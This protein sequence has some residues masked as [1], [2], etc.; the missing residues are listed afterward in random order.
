MSVPVLTSKPRY[1]ILDGLRG[2]AA[3]LV[4]AFH[5]FE[6]YSSGP[7]DQI[8]NHGY[9]AVDFFFV[10]SGFV[11]G[12]AYDDRWTKGLTLGEFA[13]RRLIRLH[14]MV[15][16]G[17]LLG[18]ALF[19]FASGSPEFPLVAQTPGWKV[20]VVALICFTMIPLGKGL[21][22]RG[23]H[24]TNP[25]NG[26]TWSLQ[27]EYLANALYAL[28]I[29]R[30]RTWMLA[31]FVAAAAFL[32]LNLALNWDIFNT[33]SPRDYAKYTVI[34]GWAL[35]PSQLTV[36]ISRLLYPFFAGLLL[37]RLRWIIPVR[38]YGFEL[39]TLLVAA[40]LCMPRVVVPGCPWANGAY[41]AAAIILVCPLIVSLGAGSTL[42]SGAMS[43]V[44]TFLGAISYPIY[45]T[46][47]PLV[48]LH[49]AW[50]KAHPEAAL[51][52]R[53][54]LGVSVWLLAMAV[55]Y[56]A[57]KL[58]DL[59]VRAWL[60]GK[61]RKHGAA[62]VHTA[63]YVTDLIRARD[64]FVTYFGAK[65][66]A[67]YTNAKTGFKS[68][69]LS[70]DSQS[71]EIMWKPG[72]VDAPKPPERTGFAHLAFGVGSPAQV[73]ALTAR[74]RTDGYKVTN[75]PRTTGDGCYESCV[76]D[77]EGNAIEITV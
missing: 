22:I 19:Y 39:C 25:L 23:W 10:L 57:L 54:I 66:N 73:D 44:C 61:S 64:F 6:S 3:A 58:Y 51:S 47:Y 27:W 20:V 41:D 7:A 75:G 59:P 46:H 36:G 52:Q 14:P 21:D 42:G 67:G 49:T 5:L 1:E 69:F 56:A 31:L 60:S 70:F 76:L 63:L 15:I 32:T 12:Y 4:V 35:S 40:I 50:V 11:I 16:M 33:L 71:L 26:P 29:R 34:G 28:V 65:P 9:L 55:A 30:F 74:L 13:K 8:L 43:R 24:E 37:S 62:V 48:Y 17:T 72:L 2:V 77:A 53:I 38:K 18:A 68:Y 45:I